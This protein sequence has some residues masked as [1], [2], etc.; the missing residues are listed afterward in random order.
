MNNG[1]QQAVTFLGNKNDKV[2]VYRYILSIEKKIEALL[3]AKE[4]RTLNYV[5]EVCKSNLSSYHLLDSV[6]IK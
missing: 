2:I 4:K 6:A 3:F 1:K 5:S